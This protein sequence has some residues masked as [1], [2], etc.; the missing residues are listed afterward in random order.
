M[1]RDVVLVLGGGGWAGAVLVPLL[2]ARG[3]R[4][5]APRSAELDVTDV[6]AVDAAVGELAPRAVVNLAAA[7]P[8]A[9]DATLDAVNHRGAEHVAAAAARGGARLV[10]VAS[11]VVFDGRHAPYAEDA[12]VCPITDYGRSKAAGEAA[13]L[14]VHPDAV[15]VRTSLLWD[16]GA[17][18]RGTASFARRLEQEPCRLFSDEIRCPLERNVLAECL[19]R[20]LEVPVRGPLNVVG[21]EALSRHAFGTLLLEHFRVEGR[22]R[23]EAACAAELEA[24]GAPPRPRDLRLHVA[25][26]VRRLGISLPGVRDVLSLSGPRV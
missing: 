3:M 1:P 20:L 21:T 4:V 13:V 16:P 26:A 12:P 2:R 10:H 14:A 19:A 8:G 5:A 15:S 7:Q 24:A 17:M 9:D 22:E 18:D 6:G 25:L 23:V 11:D